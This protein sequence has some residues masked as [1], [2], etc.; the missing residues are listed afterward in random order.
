MALKLTGDS[1]GTPTQPLQIGTLYSR[2]NQLGYLQQ[3][4][5]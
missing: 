1:I 3:E 4:V 2:Y 5:P